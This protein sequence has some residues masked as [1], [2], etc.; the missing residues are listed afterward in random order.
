MT[1]V[2]NC[3][4]VLYKYRMSPDR[5]T[6]FHLPDE[7]LEAMHAIKSRDGMPLSEQVRRALA[8]WVKYKGI[9]VKKASRKKIKRA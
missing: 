9:V 8:Q 6:A 5:Q 1:L 3:F 4:Y 2:D 7:L